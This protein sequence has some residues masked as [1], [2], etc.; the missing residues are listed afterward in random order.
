[1]EEKVL[2]LVVIAL[3]VFAGFSVYNNRQVET[4]DN[5][6]DLDQIDLTGYQVAGGAKKT[7]SCPLSNPNENLCQY[8]SSLCGGSTCSKKIKN[9]GKN[10][11]IFWTFQKAY[12][13]SSELESCFCDAGYGEVI[14]YDGCSGV[15]ST[16]C[17]TNWCKLKDIETGI[18]RTHSCWGK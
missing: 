9:I 4:S 3:L 16:S 6:V 12:C 7:C 14:I 15:Q 8:G 5:R 11:E 2:F 18:T 10:G 13:V 1:M 17:G